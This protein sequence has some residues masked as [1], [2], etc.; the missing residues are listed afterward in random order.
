[1]EFPSLRHTGKINF[2][3]ERN[4]N[5]ID[6][7]SCPPGEQARRELGTFCPASAQQGTHRPSKAARATRKATA[8]PSQ[9]GLSCR[10][11]SK[12]K[13]IHQLFPLRDKYEALVDPATGC[14][15]DPSGQVAVDNPPTRRQLRTVDRIAKWR[16]GRLL[17]SYVGKAYRNQTYFYGHCGH[18]TTAVIPHT[19]LSIEPLC[20]R[21]DGVKIITDSTRTMWC[22]HTVYGKPVVA[23]NGDRVWLGVDGRVPSARWTYAAP[24]PAVRRSAEPGSRTPNP[25]A[26]AA[27]RAPVPAPRSK[28]PA[29]KNFLE[30]YAHGGAWPVVDKGLDY[31]L[32]LAGSGTDNWP[33]DPRKRSRNL[34][35]V[36]D[37]VMGWT[38]DVASH[39]PVLGIV[40]APILKGCCHLVRFVE[41]GINAVTGFGGV[42]LFIIMLLFFVTP[43]AAAPNRVC[44]LDNGTRIITNICH[45][46]DLRYC[47]GGLCWHAPGCVVAT[48]DGCWGS[49]TPALSVA[50]GDIYEGDVFARHVDCLS[51]AV[52][53][54][55]WWGIGEACA[56]G[57]VVADLALGSVSEQVSMN[58]SMDC[59]L[60][61]V[62]PNQLKPFWNWL[63]KDT[64]LAWLIEFLELLPGLFKLMLTGAHYG[65]MLTTLAYVLDG[66]ITRALALLLVYGGVANGAPVVQS[67][68]IGNPIGPQTVCSEV[69]SSNQLYNCYFPHENR[70][71]HVNNGTHNIWKLRGRG[72]CDLYTAKTLSR[73]AW[74][75]GWGVYQPS[76]NLPDQLLTYVSTC[77]RG[78]RPKECVGE[79]DQFRDFKQ[80]FS[81]CHF[82]TNISACMRV[83]KTYHPTSEFADA[84]FRFKGK[85]IKVKCL[86]R[87]EGLSRMPGTPFP[88]TTQVLTNCPGH[89]WPAWG[90]FATQ[91]LTLDASGYQVF[92]GVM[93]DSRQMVVEHFLVMFSLCW[94]MGS[95]YVAL[96]YVAFL[97]ATVEAA[98]PLAAPIAAVAGSVWDLHPY[99]AAAT[100]GLL[101]CPSTPL[102][103]L[104]AIVSCFHTPLGF[105][106]LLVPHTIG[107]VSGITTADSVGISLP[108]WSA[109]LALAVWMLSLTPAGTKYRRAM[110]FA[111]VY[112]VDRLTLPIHGA[113]RS[114][115]NNH[116][117]TVLAFIS[118]YIYPPVACW[119]V[120]AYLVLA[121]LDISVELLVK[122]CLPR[123]AARKVTECA[124]YTMSVTGLVWLTHP[125]AWFLQRYGFTFHHHLGELSDR[126]ADVFRGAGA[127]VDPFIPRG[128]CATIV[129]AARILA[130]GDIV[131][132]RPVVARLGDLVWTGAPVCDLPDGYKLCSPVGVAADR[133]LGPWGLLKLSLTG[134]DDGPALGH[135]AVLS[136]PLGSH[137]GT[138]VGGR[139]VC[140]LHGSKGRAIA[141]ASG[142]IDPIATSP[143]EDLMA[144]S[145]PPGMLSLETCNCGVDR[146]YMIFKTGRT[147][148]MTKADG[149]WGLDTAVR[150]TEARGSSGCPAVCPQGHCVGLLTQAQN[151]HGMTSK[152]KLGDPTQLVALSAR[153]PTETVMPTVPSEYAVKTLVAAT[154]SG[155]STKIPMMYVKDGHKT[156]VLNPS[157]AT[158]AAMPAYMNQAYDI[159]PSVHY[160]EVSIT[161]DAKLTYSTYGKFLAYGI[162]ALNQYDVII[163]DE[164]HSLDSTTAL[165]IGTVLTY[166]K[167]AGAK[168]VVL[169]TATPPGQPIGPHPNITEV[170]L[171][172]GGTIPF[173]GKTVHKDQ[174]QVGRHLIFCDTKAAV[175]T[176]CQL[177][178]AE[179]LNAVP[180]WRG[181]DIT[182]I[183]LSGDVVVVSTDALATGYTG[184]FD[185]VTDCNAQVAVDLIV[186]FCPT[187]SINVRSK[188]ATSVCRAQRRGRCG[189]GKAGIYRYVVKNSM[190]AGML[191]DATLVD[192]FDGGLCWY[193]LTAAEVSVRVQA[194]AECTGLPSI[195]S[196]IKMW[197]DF[198]TLLEG[199]STN[200]R[201]VKAK[202]EGWSYPLMTGATIS[203]CTHAGTPLPDAERYEGTGKKTSKVDYLCVAQLDGPGPS[204]PEHPLVRSLQGALGIASDN[205]W[206]P[207]L[208]T[209]G[210][211]TVGVL[212]ILDSLG[213]QVR[214]GH[215]TISMARSDK[216]DGFESMNI[217]ESM[218]EEASNTLGWNEAWQTGWQGYEAAKA[219]AAQAANAASASLSIKAAEVAARAAELRAPAAEVCQRLTAAAADA[220]PV[221]SEAMG[222]AAAAAADTVPSWVAVLTTWIETNKAQ[223]AAGLQWVMGYAIL[224]RNAPVGCLLV[225]AAYLSAVLPLST[226]LFL[227][228]V[229]GG[230]SALRAPVRASVGVTLVGLGASVL[231]TSTIAGIL[232][233]ILG[234]YVSGTSSAV[235]VFKL[236]SGQAPSPDEWFAVASGVL[237]PGACLLGGILAAILSWV[238]RE[239]STVWMNRLLAMCVKG[240]VLPKDFF[241]EGSRVR[242]A[243]LRGLEAASPAGVVNSIITWLT[244]Q[245][246]IS[247]SAPGRFPAAF[248]QLYDWAIYYA[249]HFYISLKSLMPTLRAKLTFFS[250]T[251]PFTGRIKGSGQIHTVC[252]CGAAHSYSVHRGVVKHTWGSRWCYGGYY[253]VI[254]AP[255]VTKFEGSV[256]IEPVGDHRE[257][258]PIGMADFVELKFVGDDVYMS[259]TSRREVTWMSHVLPPAS[260]AVSINGACV[261]GES[262]P[263]AL[264]W[265]E[266]A[267]IVLN[268]QL[269]QLPCYIAKCEKELAPK[270]FRE[271]QEPPPKSKK[272]KIDLEA[273]PDVETWKNNGCAD[274]AENARC[275]EHSKSLVSPDASV[276]GA[277]SMTLG[278][279]TN[280][281]K[282]KKNDKIKEMCSNWLLTAEARKERG[283]VNEGFEMEELRSA[284]TSSV[285]SIPVYS[286][287]TET[288][289]KPAPTVLRRRR[290]SGDGTLCATAR[291]CMAEYFDQKFPQKLYDERDQQRA[292]SEINEMAQSTQ[293]RMFTYDRGAVHEVPLDTSSDSGSDNQGPTEGFLRRALS[294]TASFLSSGVLKTKEP[295]KDCDRIRLTSLCTASLR[296]LDNAGYESDTVGE[297][298]A[299]E[300]AAVSNEPTG[301]VADST[302]PAVL[303]VDDPVVAPATTGPTVRS[304]EEESDEKEQKFEP[305]SN[306]YV[307]NGIPVLTR[308][309]DKIFTPVAVVGTRLGKARGNVYITQPSS[310]ELRKKKVTIWRD[311][312]V[313][314]VELEEQILAAEARIKL[315]G[316]RCG[317]MSMADAAAAV[318]PRSATSFTG[319]TAAEVR[320]MTPKAKRGITEAYDCLKHGEPH[321]FKVVTIMPKAEIFARDPGK[322]YTS[323]PARI[324][325]YPPLEMRVTE[326]MIMGNVAPA[327]VKLLLGEAY[328]F[329]YTPWERANKLVELWKRRLNPYGFS[330]D[331]LCFDAQVTPSDVAT[332]TRIWEAAFAGDKARLRNLG[333]FYGTSPMINAEG[334]PLGTRHCRASGTFTTSAGNTLTC[335]LKMTTALKMARMD[336]D[337]LICGDDCVVIGE[338]P[339]N[340][341]DLKHQL[342]QLTNALSRLGLVQGDSLIPEFS[343][344]RIISCSSNVTV[345][346]NC[347]T[348]EPVYYLTRPPQTPLARGLAEARGLTPEYNWIG[349][350]VMYFPC[351]WARV[352]TIHWLEMLVTEVVQTE[353]RFQ[354]EW[355]GNTITLQ[356]HLLPQILQRLHGPQVW[357]LNTFTPD[358]SRRTAEALELLGAPRLRA[359]KA[360]AGN[361]RVA[362]MRKGGVH[363]QLA[364]Y[365]LWWVREKPPRPFSRSE[366]TIGNDLE[367]L[368]ALPYTS[369]TLHVVEG[370]D[371]P[372]LFKA[373]AACALA[374]LLLVVVGK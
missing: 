279:F 270:V 146:A 82:G 361:V 231:G 336:C 371:S 260:R 60:S 233:S 338:A 149:C 188:L 268:G 4:Q 304:D 70:P 67:S 352:L 323:K 202:Q 345:S 45:A 363:A 152:I 190:T 243:V 289:K 11:V 269:K 232:T 42:Q 135:V 20:W 247:C 324:I 124:A 151:H 201:V 312:S 78:A 207:Q 362:C 127:W 287:T 30:S 278:D 7:G 244:S 121:A 80:S 73:G 180:Y 195:G 108:G 168:L 356:L 227:A 280:M 95:R 240:N 329:Q 311:E 200:I 282:E 69:T 65:I 38:V 159:N 74:W 22:S 315:H 357:T 33:S 277:S 91:R 340:P 2:T 31:T 303:I 263:K 235:V 271:R 242:D 343:L 358:E 351:L 113:Q 318:P 8:T 57:L 179:G 18:V 199:Y 13:L 120:W 254:L 51:V 230:L 275:I 59:G 54:C 112:T 92:A 317:E 36:I 10:A 136:T 131:D 253:G 217:G 319:L 373:L 262:P 281:K 216:A 165:G 213:C 339:V 239:G 62:Y 252:E 132:G 21:A 225:G 309:M 89:V 15:V 79:P 166:A 94:M 93:G 47:A 37:G 162:G 178:Q 204:G 187:F 102:Q 52:F 177:L 197:E 19:P 104:F 265:T 257:V 110:A 354:F 71:H 266:G 101:F 125:L 167:A 369:S 355:Q 105:A 295:T 370:R 81:K 284:D 16:R 77:S 68:T 367:M 128:D 218:F 86:C 173:Y 98:V 321:K 134:V 249:R 114:I 219:W 234:A 342:L 333:L 88:R 39:T 55:D 334:T 228:L 139:L 116:H 300:A 302:E 214:T 320:R 23:R 170:E 106:L 66:R 157:V 171:D 292:I 12:A 337:L 133:G 144:Y 353:R 192:V 283:I 261:G 118:G 325:A 145:L 286:Q 119:C 48:E 191:P 49:V 223:M 293:L 56:V 237:N 294:K 182:T 154:G 194:Y 183:P 107:G 236:L 9:P 346:N 14:Y 40:A 285:Y 122:V 209:A 27:A 258:H 246:Y 184:N 335:W 143:D 115:N 215:I 6:T 100:M 255:S 169:A 264:A 203:I 87:W 313:R 241:L 306:S 332:E 229:G 85:E 117:I 226:K 176:M 155:K 220:V 63:S 238:T 349:N 310:I 17:K 46:K 374:A 41:D 181:R 205:C 189:R 206:V 328:G 326:R 314:P 359:W 296:E 64:P 34:G 58:C 3:M 185:T 365:L 267:T 90:E 111:A 259:G 83:A 350:I 142:P 290:L 330:A 24:K 158:T 1:M 137:C 327:V 25:K 61:K 160:G 208:I 210:L 28:Y 75:G 348:G 109:Y 301:E 26:G 186:D 97:L 43:A 161:T 84:S 163:C 32:K 96:V 175:T 307:W 308:A 172:S 372:V 251:P 347:V 274:C 126:A 368:T 148:R 5:E 103:S 331:A 196:D 129:D 141:T 156:L 29:K 221:A 123:G 44:R 147:V 150:M 99:Q 276:D 291:A 250:C 224:P 305:V 130:C 366:M 298:T 316:L 364:R 245:D 273:I 76:W 50:P 341:S 174:L 212:V 344:E 322:N 35:R 153:I 256:T 248:Y 360:R 272:K 193:K 53:V 140:T 138:A 222:A 288:I 164:C 299:A 72:V 211:G 198:F 297:V